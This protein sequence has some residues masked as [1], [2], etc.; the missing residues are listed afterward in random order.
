MARVGAAMLLSFLLWLMPAQLL[1]QTYVQLFRDD[2]TGDWRSSW[3]M[4]GD[5]GSVRNTPLGMELYAG[6]NDGDDSHHV[7]LWTRQSFSGDIR[8]EYD[9]TRLDTAGT[10][11]N[12]I[13]IQASGSGVGPFTEDILQWSELRKVPSMSFY[14]NHMNT[15]HVSYAAFG[16]AGDQRY[17]RARRYMP[18]S[19]GGL[20]GTE[21][22]P[23]YDPDGLFSTGVEHHVT[24]EKI[25][26][27]I[28]AVF[29]SPTTRKAVIWDAS[30]FPSIDSGRIGLRHMYTRAARYK[31]FVVSQIAPE[32]SFAP[33]EIGNGRP[34]DNRCR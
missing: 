8:I 26:F 23:H 30:E 32:P 20:R 5:V 1:A 33:S 24:I 29:E 18:E 9:F 25:G 22:I 13:Y 15:Y 14:Y 2:G 4:D 16:R 12:I 21:L 6:A 3:V 10:Y 27:E 7:V 34:T 17:I 31:N 19:G 28:T 11:V